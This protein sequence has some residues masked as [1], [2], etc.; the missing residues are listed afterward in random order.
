MI[1]ITSPTARYIR[2][3]GYIS[4]TTT[5]SCDS[6]QTIE[7]Y[8]D[9][10]CEYSTGVNYGEYDELIKDI[11]S[12]KV[13]PWELESPILKFIKKVVVYSPPIFGRKL[14]INAYKSARSTMAKFN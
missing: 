11:K 12:K 13:Y 9:I 8:D 5:S 3:G 6:T 4:T 2:S 10:Y 7:Y 14:F 1:S